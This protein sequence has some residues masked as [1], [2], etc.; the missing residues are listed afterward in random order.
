MLF[1]FRKKMKS[2]PRRNRMQWFDCW[3]FCFLLF[4]FLISQTMTSVA[5]K[6]LILL[7]F[8]I[9]DFLRFII[10]FICCVRIFSLGLLAFDGRSYIFMAYSNAALVYWIHVHMSLFPYP[11]SCG[12]WSKIKENEAFYR[13][14]CLTNF[15]KKTI[16]W[17]LVPKTYYFLKQIW[18]VLVIFWA[19]IEN[20]ENTL[21]LLCPTLACRTFKENKLNNC[22]SYS[23]YETMFCSQK[24]L[25]TVF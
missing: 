16:F 25:R 1:W 13:E 11:T 20:I 22:F 4:S 7:V 10:F 2:W 8:L 9:K 17:E 6:T 21:K 15:W 12:C 3:W 24:Q 14:I 23:S 19:T 5:S 18:D